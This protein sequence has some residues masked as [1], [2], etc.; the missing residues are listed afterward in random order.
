MR[1]C[2]AVVKWAYFSFIKMRA[3]S[4]VKTVEQ[5]LHHDIIP[6]VAKPYAFAAVFFPIS[7]RIFNI[8]RIRF[9]AVLALA[10]L[11]KLFTYVSAYIARRL[12]I[13]LVMVKDGSAQNAYIFLA[14][15][16]L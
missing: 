11:R 6:V 7:L 15:R 10:K 8:A 5:A 12:L 14:E 16:L 13:S 9:M 2:L 3:R 4:I 1:I